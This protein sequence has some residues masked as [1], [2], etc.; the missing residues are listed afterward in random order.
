MGCT[1]SESM[2]IPWCEPFTSFGW[3]GSRSSCLVGE[4][5]YPQYCLHMY[6]RANSIR[7]ETAR[8]NDRCHLTPKRWTKFRPRF[9]PIKRYTWNRVSQKIC[10]SVDF[11][12]K[13][14]DKFGWHKNSFFSWFLCPRSNLLIVDLSICNILS[15]CRFINLAGKIDRSTDR[16]IWNLST[17]RQIWEESTCRRPG[18]KI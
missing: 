7:W 16:Q 8:E 15:I 2:E 13:F 11:F 1:R 4:R 14:V 10:W 5:T 17:C 12:C 6:I 9:W 18:T 3:L